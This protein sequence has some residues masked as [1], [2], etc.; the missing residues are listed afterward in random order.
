MMKLDELSGYLESLIK[1]SAFSPY[2]S[3]I[4]VYKESCVVADFSYRGVGFA[5]DF[6]P[7]MGSLVNIH[8]VDRK[9]KFDISVTDGEAKQNI[10]ESVDL[11]IISAKIMPSLSNAINIIDKADLYDVS[12][13]VPVYNRE[14]LITGCINSINAQTL[15]KERFELIFVDDNSGDRSVSAIDYK[16]NK[17]IHYRIIKRDVGSG[18]ASAP[19]NEGIKSAK[20]NYIFF[21]DSDDEIAPTL[22][23]DAIDFAEEN[24][25]DVVYFKIIADEGIG[26]PVRPFKKGD[27]PIADITDDHLMRSLAVYKLLRRSMIKNNN[28]LFNPSI[29]VAEDKLFMCQ[30]H[31]VAKVT[32]VLANKNYYRRCRHDNESE[33]GHLSR[34][35]MSVDDKFMVY[36]GGLSAI[37][38]SRKTDT[39]KSKLYNAWLTLCVEM[40]SSTLK[41]PSL[42]RGEKLHLFKSLSIQFNAYRNLFNED[43]IYKNE[44]T[45]ANKLISMDYEGFNSFTG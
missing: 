21:M 14:N 6:F 4:W 43:M 1:G 8:M 41:K 42:T 13:I 9:G 20:G 19:R 40:L 29:A 34:R 26:A 44:R 27:V 11:S 30:I 15:D 33:D 25:S 45:L 17:D 12:V 7:L 39:E 24:N 10:A 18:N 5:M 31:A 28:I 22:L 16:I 37:T 32:S 38:F 23:E 36:S 35:G 3:K 2:L